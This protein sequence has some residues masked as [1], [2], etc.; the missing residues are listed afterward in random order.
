MFTDATIDFKSIN[1]DDLFLGSFESVLDCLPN[2]VG[3][4]VGGALNNNGASVTAFVSGNRST[5]QYPFS[6]VNIIINIV[7]SIFNQALVNFV[8]DSAANVVTAPKI[9]N[10]RG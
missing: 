3:K 2:L 4:Y 9:P 7:N 1:F 6:C 8:T 10:Y 5:L